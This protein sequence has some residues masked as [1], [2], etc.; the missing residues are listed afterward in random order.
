MRFY[1]DQLEDGVTAEQK[2][3]AAGLNWPQ[4]GQPVMVLAVQGTE[5]SANKVNKGQVRSG[6]QAGQT[7]IWVGRC[8]LVVWKVTL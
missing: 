2:P 8:W 1:G 6:A 7:N 5:E 3:A 4:Q